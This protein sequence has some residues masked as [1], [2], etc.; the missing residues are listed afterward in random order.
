[1]FFRPEHTEPID[2]LVALNASIR[3]GKFVGE[4]P[5]L[6]DCMVMCAKKWK[7]NRRGS[8]ESA[9]EDAPP[10]VLDA[11]GDDYEQPSVQTRYD[12]QSELS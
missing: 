10:M 2:E 4:S 3:M 7:R 11:K 5:P 12:L 1:M 6:V 9:D 8:G